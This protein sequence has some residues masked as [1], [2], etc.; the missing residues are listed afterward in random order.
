MFA[1]RHNASARDDVASREAASNQG[2]AM[3]KAS[4]ALLARALAGAVPLPRGAVLLAGAA[5]VSG[6][7]LLAGP[8]HAQDMEFSLDEAEQQQQQEGSAEGADMSFEEGETQPTQESGSGDVIG[9]LATSEAGAAEGETREA[10]TQVQEAREEIFAVQQVYAL[11]INR[12]EI[13][14]TVSFSLNDPFV[15]HTGV[16]VGLNYWWT[17]VLA[18]GV[19][20]IWY[21]GLENESD[22]GYFVRRATRLAVPV[23]SYQFGAHLAFTY[24]PIYGKFAM[25]NEFI[26][27]YDIYV[28]GGVGLMNTRP[29]PVIDPEVRSFNFDIRV[30]FNVG[31]GLRVFVTRWLAIVAELR[32]Y[33]YLEQLENLEVALG[34]ERTNP[35]TWTQNSPAFINNVTAHLGLTIFLPFDFEYRLPR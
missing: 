28:L 24:V 4:V 31:I 23:N 7:V 6:S 16:G 19:N 32:D 33:M 2:V 18:L 25:F 1:A 3:R 27:Q 9:D 15:Q 22:I 5:L 8:A 35:E 10:P 29:I 11:R 30:A 34:A 14:P 26:F 17:N 20:F 13:T 21:E 12:V